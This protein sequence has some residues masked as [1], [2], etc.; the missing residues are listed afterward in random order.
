MFIVSEN[1]KLYINYEQ[2]KSFYIQHKFDC[3]V[4]VANIGNQEYILADRNKTED[5]VK[6]ILGFAIDKSLGKELSVITNAD[7]KN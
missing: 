6:I 4:L 3:S 2:V 1:K 5:I 7:N